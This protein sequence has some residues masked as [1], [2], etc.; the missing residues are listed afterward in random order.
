MIPFYEIS[1]HYLIYESW[2]EWFEKAR[3][4]IRP[5]QHLTLTVFEEKK[6]R[7]VYALSRRI[8]L[9]DQIAC[10]HPLNFA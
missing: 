6:W 1:D 9:I 10:V 4:F 3:E 5:F 8:V 2:F 7:Q